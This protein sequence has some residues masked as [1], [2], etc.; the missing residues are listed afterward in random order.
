M[1]APGGTGRRDT[2]KGCVFFRVSPWEPTIDVNRLGAQNLNAVS[3]TKLLGVTKSWGCGGNGGTLVLEASAFARES[4]NLSIPTK[5]FEETWPSG[6][7]RRTANAKCHL[8]APSVRIGSSPPD[9]FIGRM[10]G[11]VSHLVGVRLTPRYSR[12]IPDESYS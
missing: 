2:L 3:V 8:E 11:T 12:G 6:P 7:R 1:W 9:S 4:S 10:S 5:G